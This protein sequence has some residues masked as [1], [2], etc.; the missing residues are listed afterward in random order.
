MELGEVTGTR[1]EEL[2]PVDI[3]RFVLIMSP[4]VDRTDSVGSFS[5]TALIDIR[6]Y[7]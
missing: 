4:S 3:D 7:A 1:L 5:Q 2:S 6:I